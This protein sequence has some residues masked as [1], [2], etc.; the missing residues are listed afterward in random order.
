MAARGAFAGCPG[1]PGQVGPVLWWGPLDTDHGA[2]AG[3]IECHAEHLS[4]P[5]RGGNWYCQVYRGEAQ[6]FHT[7]ECG[8]EPCSGEAAWWLCEVVVSVVQAGVW[9]PSTPNLLRDPGVDH[10]RS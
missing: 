7:A 6:Y 1:L 10:G 9:E 4:G 3:G 8:I 5:V 2:T